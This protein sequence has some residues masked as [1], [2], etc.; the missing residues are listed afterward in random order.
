MSTVKEEFIQNLKENMRKNLK[1]GLFTY[2]GYDEKAVEDFNKILDEE[3]FEEVV[4]TNTY[5]LYFE[6]DALQEL[7]EGSV[8]TSN[9]IKS[10]LE[11][12]GETMD[13]FDKQIAKTINNFLDHFEDKMFEL[14][15]DSSKR[16]L[17]QE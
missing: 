2:L 9:L 15:M 16:Q 12:S 3:K 7:M 13:S 4:F 14:K 5:K 11:K 8:K 17:E 6:E 1:S 10:G